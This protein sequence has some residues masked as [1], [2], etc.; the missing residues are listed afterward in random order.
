MDKQ[1]LSKMSIEELE[2]MHASIDSYGV[3]T[4]SEARKLGG[5]QAEI[6]DEIRGRH[7]G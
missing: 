5:Y 4:I 2:R 6:R 3:R 1:M 7:N